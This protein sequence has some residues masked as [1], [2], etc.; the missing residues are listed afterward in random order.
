MLIVVVLTRTNVHPAFPSAT[1]PRWFAGG[2]VR[3]LD[4]QLFAINTSLVRI[5]VAALQSATLSKLF[6]RFGK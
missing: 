1:I 6:V 3:E 5:P 2:V 4:V